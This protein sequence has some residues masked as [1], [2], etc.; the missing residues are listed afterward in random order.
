MMENYIKEFGHMFYTRDKWTEF[1]NKENIQ[2]SIGSRFHGNMMAFSNGIPAMWIVHDFRTKELVEAM[3]LPYIQYRD[4]SR[5]SMDEIMN[6]CEY[7]QMCIR[8]R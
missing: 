5:Y 8:D 3:E 1:L 7:G 4:L 2:F 6:K